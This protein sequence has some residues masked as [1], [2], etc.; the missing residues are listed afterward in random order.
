MKTRI[1]LSLSFVILLV[2]IT[3]PAMAAA[4]RQTTPISSPTP[5]PDGRI[6]YTVQT[7]D[8]VWSIAANFNIPLDELRTLNGLADDA[9]IAPGD[10]IFLGLG[11]PATAIPAAQATPTPMPAGPTPTVEIGFGI[12]CVILYDDINGD[13]IRQEEEVSIPGGAISIGNATGTVSLTEDTLDGLDHFCTTEIEEGEYTI[14]VGAPDGYN[15]TTEFSAAITLNPGDESY[16]DFGAQ[17][18][19][20]KVAEEPA[21]IG[22]GPS[23]TLG[24]IGAAVILLGIILGVY[25]IFMR[26]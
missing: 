1:L 22:E 2:G 18:N 26:R 23:P 8:S 9:V 5:G 17:K 10:E 13:A 11:G 12:L 24:I 7:G 25:A 21:P 20:V 15:P 6:I 4:P 14:T 16:L 19:S 3:L